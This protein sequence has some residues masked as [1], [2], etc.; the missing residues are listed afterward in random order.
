MLI[1]TDGFGDPDL[2][3]AQ[4]ADHAAHPMATYSEED[5]SATQ[6]VEALTG[7]PKWIV[8]ITALDRRLMS[9]EE[10]V[11]ELERGS[12]VA[13]ETLVWRAGMLDWQPIASIE[14]LPVIPPG[15]AAP[16]AELGKSRDASQLLL[17]SGALAI[18]VLA[19][20]VTIY[21]LGKG[22]VFDTGKG[23]SPQRAAATS[24]RVP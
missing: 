18:A 14:G 24:P 12:L 2:L 7:E 11:A 22:G 19:A 16:R 8:K 13:R 15:P 17:A 20:S 3:A 1:G 4:L 10:L 9:N 23:E 5:D 6:V 21:A